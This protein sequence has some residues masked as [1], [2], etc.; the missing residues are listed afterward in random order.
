MNIQGW[1]CDINRVVQENLIERWHFIEVQR[2][3]NSMLTLKEVCR[4]SVPGREM[5][6][7][8]GPEAGVLLACCRNSKEASAAAV[9]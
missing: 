6:R 7:C 1:D 5:S 8:K 9:D 2:R 4:K 3:G